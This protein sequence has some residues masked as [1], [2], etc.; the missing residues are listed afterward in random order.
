MPFGTLVNSICA[1]T[2]VDSQT[3]PFLSFL[4]LGEKDIL[5]A[6]K[7]CTSAEVYKQGSMS[8]PLQKHAMLP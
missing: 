7:A 8:F 6:L 4:S 5:V 1:N 2:T 3:T